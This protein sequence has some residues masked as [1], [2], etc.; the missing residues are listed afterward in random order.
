MMERV[1]M[2]TAFVV[3]VRIYLKTLKKNLV[4]KLNTQKCRLTLLA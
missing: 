1:Q 3:S 2:A 4:K